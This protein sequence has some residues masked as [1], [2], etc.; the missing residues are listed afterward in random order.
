MTL[1]YPHYV[2]CMRKASNPETRRKMEYAFNRRC[3]EENTK[4]LE[5]LV[6]LRQKMAHLLGYSTH[7]NY[8]LEMRMAKN[9]KAVADFL[10]ALSTKLEPL[11][12]DELKVLLQLKQEECKSLGYDFDGKINAWDMRYYMSMVEEKNYSVDHE[13]LKEYFPLDVVTKGLLDI[14]QELLGLVFEEIQ[15]P[16]VWHKDV[17][18]FSVKDKASSAIIGYFYLDLF[19]REGKFSHA[20]CFGL[21]PGCLRSDGK[22]QVNISAME[23]NFTQPTEDKPSLLTHNE[24]SSTR[25][26]WRPA[27]ITKKGCTHLVQSSCDLRSN[28]L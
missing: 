7:A 22:R 2:P 5:E 21:K 4:I 1:K 14:Y 15:N 12:Q 19:P 28:K 16:H 26:E 18:L 9:A 27:D 24:V 8:I 11:L 10:S 3:F 25:T 13:K 6:D 17:Q 23:A 20:A